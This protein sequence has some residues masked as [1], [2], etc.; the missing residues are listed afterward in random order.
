MKHS[1]YAVLLLWIVKVQAHE[2]L[3]YQKPSKEILDLVDVPLVPSVFV[4]DNK[5]FNIF[6]YRDTFKSIEEIS[7]EEMRL[8]GLRINP[9]T[10][11]GSSVMYYNNLK[12]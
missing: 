9:K 10:N 8:G 3:K 4:D 5:D 1:I 2:S 11:F 6:Q 7:Q 12:I